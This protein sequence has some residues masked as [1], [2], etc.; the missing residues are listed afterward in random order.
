MHVDL[1]SEETARRRAKNV[2]DV[3]KRMEYR[4]AHGLE[5]EEDTDD[6]WGAWMARR[7]PIENK[8]HET[9]VDATV[10]GASAAV[11]GA[12]SGGSVAEQAQGGEEGFYR[13]SEGRVKRKKPKMWLGIW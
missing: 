8:G 1:I 2:D 4:R 10:A 5:P 13:D 6:K 7:K 12:E 9:E 3:Q 11:I